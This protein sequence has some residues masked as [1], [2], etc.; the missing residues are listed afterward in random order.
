[1]KLSKCIQFFFNKNVYLGV[2]YDLSKCDVPN[3][4][5]QEWACPPPPPL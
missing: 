1:M 4:T 3:G 2:S 5:T